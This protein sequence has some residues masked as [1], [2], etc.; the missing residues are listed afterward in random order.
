MGYR[1]Q[2]RR[3][4]AARWAEM[5]P[6]LLE[7]EM[8]IV[9]DD[10]NQYKIGDG[11]HTWNELPL[12]GFTGTIAQTLGNNENAVA[13]Q[14]VVT[15]KFAEQDEKLSDI[16]SNTKNIN[17][18]DLTPD[19]TGKYY[20]AGGV[21]SDSP[22]YASKE[23]NLIPYIGR[24]LKL[25]LGFSEGISSYCFIKTS[26]G[27]YLSL[28]NNLFLTN[29]NYCV[30]Y[31]E[32]SFST[33]QASWDTKNNP[34]YFI[35]VIDIFLNS[36]ETRNIE[37]GSDYESV[38]NGEMLLQTNTLEANLKYIN[39]EIL[40]YYNNNNILNEDSNWRSTTI[41]VKEGTLLKFNFDIVPKTVRGI[42]VYE[43][44]TL[45]Y[46]NTYPLLFRSEGS[47][48]N[49]NFSYYARRDCTIVL[50]YY[51]DTLSIY[52]IFNSNNFYKDI[53]NNSSI[54]YNADLNYPDNYN[55]YYSKGNSLI[56]FKNYNSKEVNVAE[57]GG[58]KLYIRCGFKG[59]YCNYCFVKLY[60]NTFKALSDYIVE[61]YDTCCVVE[62]PQNVLALQLSWDCKNLD[63]YYYAVII[64]NKDVDNRITTIENQINGFFD[65]STDLLSDV[66]WNYGSY[67]SDGGEKSSHKNYKSTSIDVTNYQGKSLFVSVGYGRPDNVYG[68]LEYSFIKKTDGTYVKI[69]NLQ[70]ILEENRNGYYVTMPSDAETLDVSYDV[71][72]KKPINPIVSYITKGKVSELESKVEESNSVSSK[73]KGKNIFLFGDS[74]SSTDYTWYKDYLKKYTGA[75]AVYNQG[76]SGRNAAYQASNEYFSR[77]NTNPCDIIIAL[78]GG[79]DSGESGSIGTFSE[80]S[81]L[82]RLGESIVTETN[83][84]NDYAGTKFIQAISHIIRKWKNEY[85]NYRLK[86]NLSAKIVSSNDTSTPLYEGTELQCLEYAKQQGLELGYGKSYYM[87]TTETAE[88]KREKL[89]GVKMPKLYF[90]TTL[91]Q[92]RYNDSNSY[93]KPENW[94]RKRLAIIE[95]C[96]KYEIPCIDLA[97]EFAIDWSLEPYWPGQGY[98]GTSKT[99][100]Q[101]IYTMDGLHPNEFGYDWIARIISNHI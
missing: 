6:I 101:G 32:D 88:S 66:V 69:R 33:L 26:S 18:L 11:V 14:K 94:E 73:F 80:D 8:G 59:S 89:I 49:I 71:I 83:I 74:I 82:H 57:F 65:I 64:T 24:Y 9:L 63:Y 17:Y 39:N 61:Q 27:A 35:S 91:P 12:R 15:E 72:S 5:N 45:V 19:N 48:V 93:S 70:C 21:L 41:S 38:V 52:E 78:I 10:P 68:Y 20:S 16:G 7:G 99:D 100:N 96:K 43:E 53:I 92:K 50:S 67:W 97:K 1:I 62:L 42:A 36:E 54:L 75:E 76:A 55:K 30:L 23:I 34:S 29:D 28:S 51:K 98:S 3:D 46:S 2:N 58:K 95:C 37:F 13:S 40:G 87:M 44:N 84:S 56:D 31:V 77:L 86:A 25:R 81:E 85:Y 90:C 4:T 22:N 60:D 47:I 79:N